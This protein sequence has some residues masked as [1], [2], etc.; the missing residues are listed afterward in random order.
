MCANKPTIDKFFNM[1]KDPL[2]QFNIKN[3]MHIWNTDE[4]GIQDILKEEKAIGVVGEKVHMMSPKEQGETTTILMFAN[5]HGQVFP[6]LVIFKGTKV[7]DAWQTN[8]LPSVTVRAS[9]KEWI[10][11]DVFLNYGVRWVHWLKINQRLGKPHLLLLDAHK[12]HIYNLPF[13]C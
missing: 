8:A 13:F 11:K 1:Y 9:P 3:P 12:S 6:L 5:A 2:K 7:S 10:N 4:S